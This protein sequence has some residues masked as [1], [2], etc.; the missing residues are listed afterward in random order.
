VAAV[1][2]DDHALVGVAVRSLGTG[3]LTTAGP[4]QVGPAWSTIKVPVVLA[5]YRLADERHETDRSGIDDLAA[6]AITQSDNAAAAELF[7]Q[8]ETAKGG[9]TAASAYVGEE[10]A[11]AGD[12]RTRINTVNPGN[13][14]STYGQTQ[15]SLSA[16]TQF[17]RQL[18]RNCLPPRDSTTRVLSLMEQVV[19]SQRWGIGSAHWPGVP[20]L[21]LKGGW[22]PDR[23][24]RYLV[25]Q[26]GV[27][28]ARNM[29]GFA[30]GLIAQPNDGQFGSGV[31]VLD[32]LAAA[33][34]KATTASGTNLFSSCH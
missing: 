28:E 4:L 8:I 26:F 6:R 16:G 2:R 14:F 20:S 18:A 12:G 13:G 9:L 22:G 30:V 11:A 31:R 33:V 23:N 17:Y 21:R 27:V 34:A 1:S 19:P 15:W 25:R 32:D 29:R 3:E 10:L 24:G 5:R 7:A